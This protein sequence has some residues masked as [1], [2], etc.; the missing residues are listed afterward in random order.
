MSRTVTLIVLDESGDLLGELPTFDVSVPFWPE[1]AEIVA[2]AR[3]RYGLDVAVLRLLQAADDPPAGGHVTYLAQLLSPATGTPWTPTGVDLGDHPLRAPYARPGGPARLLAWAARALDE[4]GRGPVTDATQQRTWNLS[5]V[6]RLSTPTGPYWLKQVPG[7]FAHEPA[8]LTW[9]AGSG[10]TTPLLAAED[11]T[12]L[13][14]HV[15]GADLYGAGVDVRRDIAADMHYLQVASIDSVPHLIAD[16]VPDRRQPRLADYLGRVIDQYGGD[17]ASLRALAAGLPERLDKIAACGLPDTLVHG[18]LHPGN[19]IGGDRRTIIDW[20]DSFIGHPAFDVLRL[21]GGMPAADD[22]IVIEDWAARWRAEIAGSDPRAA[23]ELLR[24][25]AAL[26][27]AA[28][29]ADFLAGI[30]P[31]EHPYHA[32]DVAIWLRRAAQLY[33]GEQ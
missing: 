6:W 13:L 28:V 15:D 27:L 4:R 3:E 17:D 7:F 30:E 23:V 10:R 24:P 32:G 1:T 21:T 5:T 2:T 25:L 18:D 22:E 12:M 16:G 11:A 33:E 31:S 9:A 19:V 14:A 26:R 20:G 8:V 29:Y